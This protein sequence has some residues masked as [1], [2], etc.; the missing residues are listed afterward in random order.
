MLS[1]HHQAAFAH[2]ATTARVITTGIGFDLYFIGREREL[3]W[4]K[5]LPHAHRLS[6]RMQSCQGPLLRRS[7]AFGATMIGEQPHS[8]QRNVLCV[9]D[10]CAHVIATVAHKGAMQFETGPR[11]FALMC[12][13][14]SQR[15]FTKGRIIGPS[16]MRRGVVALSQRGPLTALINA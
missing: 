14:V 12:R 5:N 2:N 4:I 3:L 8:S 1:N 15:R 16:L 6:H 9:F 10:H 11:V 7:R 13:G